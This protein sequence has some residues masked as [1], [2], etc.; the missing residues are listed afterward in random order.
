S[1]IQFWEACTGQRRGRAFE[2]RG[3]IRDTKSSPDGWTVLT[4][5][6]LGVLCL[7]DMATGK[8]VRQHDTENEIDAVAFSPDGRTVLSTSSVTR[9]AGLRIHRK[10]TVRFWDASP[11]EPIGAS[12]DPPAAV[13]AA[14]FSPDGRTVV[15][16][17]DDGAARL[18]DVATGKPVGATLQHQSPV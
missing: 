15:T 3:R 1:Q 9:K 7:W 17:C 2:I 18:W 11:W 13:R 4:G 10:S 16:G 12:L 5:T 14:A 8:P 6:E